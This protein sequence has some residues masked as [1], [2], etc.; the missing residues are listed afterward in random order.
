MPGDSYLARMA[1]NQLPLHILSFPR[2]Q[3]EINFKD[4]WLLFKYLFDHFPGDFTDSVT[5]P[6]EADVNIYKIIV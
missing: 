1:D 3:T 5:P 4:M 6:L 2:Y